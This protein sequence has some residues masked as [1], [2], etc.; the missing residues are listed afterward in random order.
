MLEDVLIRMQDQTDLQPL[1]G[2]LLPTIISGLVT[3]L[4]TTREASR[5]HSRGPPAQLNKLVPLINNLILKVQTEPIPGRTS[6]CACLPVTNNISSIWT[7]PANFISGTENSGCHCRRCRVC[8]LI[9]SMLSPCQTCQ[10]WPGRSSCWTGSKRG[11]AFV[12]S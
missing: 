3:A 12:T 8:T 11:S 6:C 9:C 1:L 10:S 4:E 2:A 7:C 5:E